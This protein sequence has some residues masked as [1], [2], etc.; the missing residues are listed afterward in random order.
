MDVNG[1][2]EEEGEVSLNIPPL[3][4]LYLQPWADMLRHYSPIFFNLSICLV[5]RLLGGKTAPFLF[6][7]YIH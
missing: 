3:G 7:F 4:L 2:W 6:L 5:H 1:K